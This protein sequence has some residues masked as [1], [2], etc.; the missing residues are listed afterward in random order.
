MSS[1]SRG[2]KKT[3]T[4]L[5]ILVYSTFA[6]SPSKACDC[7]RVWRENKLSSAAGTKRKRSE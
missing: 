6:A 2:R 7:Y 3:V 4:T 5:E 1:L